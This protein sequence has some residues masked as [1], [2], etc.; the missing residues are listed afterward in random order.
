MF[1]LGFLV[2]VVEMFNLEQ[3]GKIMMSPPVPF[4]AIFGTW[5]ADAYFR[6]FTRPI[7]AYL[8]DPTVAREKAAFECGRQ[9]SKHYW[10]FF[11]AFLAIAPVF[12]M[13]G[14]WLGYGFVPGAVD[15]FRIE[16][17]SLVVS[18]IVG[19]PIFFLV[20]DVFGDVFRDMFI[21][22]PQ[23]TIVR[24]V[25]LIGALVPLLIDTMLVQYYWTETGYFTF[26]TFLVWLV[27]EVLA[28]AG[29]VMFV[30][31]FRQA[32]QPL[33]AV[34]GSD[35]DFNQ[36]DFS[37]LR[38]HSTDELG[39]LASGYRRVL[40]GLQQTN[41]QLKHQMAERARVEQERV[42]LVADLE[43]KNEE[44][45]RFTYTVSHD[46]KSPLVTIRGFVGVVEDELGNDSEAGRD[47]LRRI[48]SAAERMTSLLDELLEMSRIGRVVNETSSVSWSALAR[49]AESLCAGNIRQRG[50]T[51]HIEDD[52]P[53]VH[54]DA[55]RMVQAL[56]NLIDN[57]CKYAGDEPNPQI[58]I[59]AP[60]EG[61]LHVRD[62]GIG[63]LPE[64]HSRIFD[65]FDKLDKSTPGSGIGL[66]VVRRIIETHGGKVCVESDGEGAGT[67]FVITIES[68]R[69]NQRNALD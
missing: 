11:L 31:S 48:R 5:S 42:R 20:F 50:V 36:I 34:V 32:L 14:A 2:F 37:E 68:E 46:L 35:V 27:L 25:F 64:Y 23:L 62:N 60:R 61:E 38:P 49:E 33:S 24:K 26:V 10:A 29:A 8:E 39:V 9:F 66:A 59:E 55:K 53:V 13:A 22:K 1:G 6:R 57:A 21:A 17:V 63:I 51:V 56:Q 44:L 19:L 54:V 41:L 3:L 7:V 43:M 69:A 4:L 45:E 15:W 67:T 28:V 47:G 52:L 18:I 65:L 30:R 12:V 16:L 58:V 40:R